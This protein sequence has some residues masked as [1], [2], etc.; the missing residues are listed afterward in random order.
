MEPVLFDVPTAGSVGT[1]DTPPV[2]PAEFSD[3]ASRV[4]VGNL[5]WGV[6][7]DTLKN[8]M[9]QAG[10][11]VRAD[12]LIGFDGRSKG[13]GI[14]QYAD[15]QSAR[16]AQNTLYDSEIMGRKILVREDKVDENSATKPRPNFGGHMNG[17]HMNGGQMNG[18][19]M[20]G[21]QMNGIANNGGGGF[22]QGNAPPSRRCYVGNLS[23]DVAWQD[24]KDHMRQAGEVVY[25]EVLTEEGGRS[26]GCGI[27]EYSTEA[28]AQ[29]A[30][31]L[32]NNTQIN[33]REIFVREDRMTSKPSMG[34]GGMG[35]GGGAG[36][37]TDGI[38]VYVGNLAW[39]VDWRILKDHMAP[40]GAIIRADVLTGADGRSKGC[41]IVTFQQ[42]AEAA[43]AIAEMQNTV[44]HDRPIFVR[45]DRE[46]GKGRVGGGGGGVGGGPQDGGATCSLFVFNLNFQTDWR[47]LKDYFRGV[48]EVSRAEVV[49]G[50]GCGTV[51]FKRARDAALAIERLNGTVLDGMAIGVQYYQFPQAPGQG[52]QQP[53]A[54]IF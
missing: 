5:A 49:D 38:S 1:A 24:L 47:A 6:D 16:N 8:H 9:S 13:C 53:N 18:G 52:L 15:E 31:Q 12:V 25:A 54:Q 7:S 21:G 48:G 30:I 34:G 23:W 10:H 43:R 37:H 44:L 35:V 29:S 14:V 28:Y 33:G 20:N 26:K 2:P 3:K 19:Q 4:F 27:V 40:M 32:L 50:K 51:I 46:A 45:E 41:G 22:N 39:T 42:P 17:G 11:V 36:G